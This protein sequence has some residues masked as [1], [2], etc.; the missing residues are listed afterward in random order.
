M[1][2]LAPR[3]SRSEMMALLS[4]ALSAISP[5]KA[6]PLISGGTPSVA[7]DLDD[8][9]VDHGVFHIRLVRDG[10]EQPLPH[11]RLHPVAEP[12]I[13]ADPAAEGGRQI[14]PG[15]ACA[16]NPK[17]RLQKQPVI[18]APAPGIARLAQTQR[19]HPRPLGVSQNESVHPK[20]ESH[21]ASDENP[22]SKQ[23]LAGLRISA[24]Y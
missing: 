13:H 23:A 11:I 15:T 12:R 16:R 4:K 7:V 9:G 8:G 2:T 18:L 20:L 1:T 21:P 24:G 19:L 14:A 10:L 17:H 3:A 22:E 5:P 6:S